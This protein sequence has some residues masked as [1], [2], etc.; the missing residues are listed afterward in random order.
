MTT[1]HH[2]LISA[3]ATLAAPPERIYGIIADYH[4]GHPSILPPQF[5]SMAVERGGV[6]EGTIIAFT[7]RL[8][9]RTQRFRAAI[10]EP[11]PGRILMETDLDT[12]GAVTTFIVDPGPAAGQSQVTITTNL[13]VRGGVLGRIERVLSRKLLR[14]IYVRELEL[15][16]RRAAGA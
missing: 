6:G 8:L 2:H 14:P 15:L 5:T 1:N 10:T 13:I 3:S 16:A 4:D 11:E 12:T 9:G 7:M